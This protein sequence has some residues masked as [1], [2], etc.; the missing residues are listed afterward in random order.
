MGDRSNSY[1]GSRIQIWTCNG[2]NAQSW[3]FWIP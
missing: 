1:D 2:I 3:D